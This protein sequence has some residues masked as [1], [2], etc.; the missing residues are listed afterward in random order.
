MA[1]GRLPDSYCPATQVACRTLPET[2]LEILA[3][4]VQKGTNFFWG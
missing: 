2:S 4:A 1:H 3:S